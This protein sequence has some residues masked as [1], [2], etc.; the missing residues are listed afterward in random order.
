[1]HLTLQGMIIST[2][3]T[4]RNNIHTCAIYMSVFNKVASLP[5]LLTV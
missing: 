4:M 3:S 1:M 5:K 2:H